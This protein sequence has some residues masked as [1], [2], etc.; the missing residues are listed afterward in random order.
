MLLGNI[1][2]K[3][4]IRVMVIVN[5]VLTVE[6]NSLQRL[7]VCA[8]VSAR[9]RI[10]RRAHLKLKPETETLRRQIQV[11]VQYGPGTSIVL[12]KN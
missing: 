11:F 1:A 5:R 12:S 9:R 10:K 7:N 8:S 2:F 4:R 6:V 3:F